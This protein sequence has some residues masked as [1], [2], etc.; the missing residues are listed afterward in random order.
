MRTAKKLKDTRTS[1]GTAAKR[2]LH[3]PRK[4]QKNRAPRNGDNAE[5]ILD[6]ALNLFARSSFWAVTI[7]DIGHATGLNAA[8]I[9]YYFKDK[10][11]LFRAAVEFSVKRSFKEFESRNANADGPEAIISGWLD[12]HINELDLIRKLVKV[13]LDYANSGNRIIRI[14][15]A[16]R[17]FYDHERTILM[18]AMRNGIA[19]KRFRAIDVKW[20]ASFI[21]TF[22]DGV[23]VRSMI[24]PDFDPKSAIHG[25]RDFVLS[26]LKTR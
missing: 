3:S 21:S 26:E 12:T 13:S 14:D 18:T 10:E 22:L 6:V 2:P 4:V 19:S 16:I 20:M 15:K 17:D 24:S 7:K 11:D 5:R 9:Y 23:M 25:L 8:M 1:R